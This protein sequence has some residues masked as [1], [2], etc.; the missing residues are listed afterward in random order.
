MFPILFQLGRL[1]I[2]TIGIFI[3]IGFF[4]A[5]F[6]FWRA[7]RQEHYRED[8]LFDDLL[9]TAVWAAMASRLGFIALHTD[10]FGLDLGRWVDIFNYPGISMAIGVL[11]IPIMMWRLASKKKLDTFEVLDF[12][13]VALSVG[14]VWYWI[15][16]FFDGSLVGLPTTLPWG[17]VFPGLFTPR[18]PAQLYAVVANI[19]VTIYLLWAQNKYRLFGWYRNNHHTANSGFLF[20]AWLISQGLIQLLLLLVAAPQIQAGDFVLD[21]YIYPMVIVLGVWLLFR[22]SGRSIWRWRK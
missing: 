4:S 12:S 18:H 6:V 16:A 1:T 15:G 9:I 3:A 2:H 14:L 11:I 8:E 7:S 20:C 17:M 10:V 22:R 19:A 21:W 5:G 13:A